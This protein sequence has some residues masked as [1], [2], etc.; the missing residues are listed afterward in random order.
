MTDE[1]LLAKKLAL[2]ETYVREVRTLAVPH[3]IATN[4]RER[5]FVQYTLQMA[6]QAAIDI[7]SH[8]VSDDRLGEPTTNGQLF[9]LLASAGW[10][11]PAQV[12]PLRRMAGFR[13]VLVHG[14]AEVDP[15]VVRDVV[16]NHLGDLV[17][18]VAA[19]RARLGKSEESV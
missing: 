9:E 17:A 5:R 2:I 16:E 10:L 3:E 19:V 7:A 6:I 14:Y 1:D 4:V 13:N 15:E 11:S 12:A 8:I 18:Y